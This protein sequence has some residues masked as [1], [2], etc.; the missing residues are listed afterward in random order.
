MGAGNNKPRKT[1]SDKKKEVKATLSIDL[2]DA[3]YRLSFLTLTHVK[4]VCEYLCHAALNERKIIEKLSTNFLH[5]IRY[6]D[7]LFR[8]HLTNKQIEKRI[9][10]TTSRVTLKF[11]RADYEAIYSLSYA[12]EVSPSRTTAI[13]LDMSMKD[14]SIVN[15]YVKDYLHD[16]LTH[17]QMSELKYLLAYL[18]RTN[19]DH[20]TW[21]ALLGHIYEMKGSPMLEVKEIVQEFLDDK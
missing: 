8:G 19:S 21:A 16:N 12:L 13:L 15:Q 6:S 11:K 1:R 17:Y 10:G 3:I 4:D 20:H 9:S 7:T 5:D 2:K 18:N 14:I